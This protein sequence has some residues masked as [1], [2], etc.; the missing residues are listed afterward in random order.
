MFRIK[1]IIVSV[2][3]LTIT[4][5]LFAQEVK[6]SFEQPILKENFDSSSTNWTIVSNTDNFFIVQDGEYILNRK[7][8][9]S[10]FAIISGIQY[11]A[12]AYKLIT[13]LKLE[14]AID[15]T[16]SIGLLFQLQDD[17]KGGFLF[18]INK[19]KQYR[20]REIAGAGYKNITGDTKN[21]G[22]LKADAVN[23]LGLANLI[24]FRFADSNYDL[25]INNKFTFTFTNSNYKNGSFGFVIGPG[26]KGKID[27]VYLFKAADKTENVKNQND[28][29]S[30]LAE[31]I[32]NMKTQINKLN[33][34]NELLR[35]TIDAMKSQSN[36][37]ENEKQKLQ[38]EINQNMVDYNLLKKVNDS[39][40][41]A[42]IDLNKYKEMVVG[43]DNGDLVINLSK[44][45]KAEKEKNNVLQQINQKLE[46]ELNALK[47]QNKPQQIQQENKSEPKKAENFTLPK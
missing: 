21:N 31:S 26:S 39:L 14:K 32:I 24:D 6:Y 11:K 22:W 43:N 36:G 27:F 9:V 4:A 29:I 18:E 46:E 17:R 33:D 28:D 16:G 20:I 8:V 47:S 19:E 40:I 44:S 30:N 13:S 41:K 10:P 25:Y 37:F 7:S 12:D 23:D 3:L 35:K 5:N 45:L 38:N 15:Q 42:N 1:I 2:L 34:E